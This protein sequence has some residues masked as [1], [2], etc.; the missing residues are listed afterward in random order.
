MRDNRTPARCAE[1]VEVGRMYQF[2]EV[3]A[4]CVGGND[5]D[6]RGK[7]VALTHTSGRLEEAS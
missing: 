5:E 3:L 1:V 7:G 6:S 2:I 4:Q